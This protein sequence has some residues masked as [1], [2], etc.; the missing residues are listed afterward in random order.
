MP[1]PHLSCNKGEIAKIVL[2]P[3]NP[4]R[5][6]YMAKKFLTNP[7]LVSS[8]RNIYFYTGEYKGKLVTIGASGMGVASMGIYAYELFTE[9]DVDVII[10]LGSTGSYVDNLDIKQP[11]LVKRAYAD[12]LGFVSLMTGEKTHN[13]YPDKEIVKLLKRS[14]KKKKINVLDVSCHTTDVF[15][16]IRSLEETIN[17]TKCQVVDNECFGLFTTA[18]RCN[19]KAAALLSVSENIVTG[20]SMTS[21]ERLLEFSQMFE[22]ALNALDNIYK[23]IEN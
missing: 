9:Y 15:Y 5:A 12:G 10:R 11:V 21:D 4:L 17:K 3:G 14:A 18:K 6:E 2:M 22:V 23:Y 1:T 20:K 8:V 13:A 16:S 19:K 7:K